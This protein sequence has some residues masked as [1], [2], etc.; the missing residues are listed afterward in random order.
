MAALNIE[1]RQA[2]NITILSLSGRL[3]LGES[4]EDFRQTIKRLVE[5]GHNRILVNLQGVT[6]VDSSGLGSLIA[7]FTSIK[8]EG[9]QFKL[10][11]LNEAMQNLM[12]MTKLLTVFE[13]YESENE[14]LKS[15]G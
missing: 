15:F 7:C 3:T 12:L 13:V 6:R 14:A 5:G 2:D 10:V 1:E 8:K 9:G 11:H 4:S